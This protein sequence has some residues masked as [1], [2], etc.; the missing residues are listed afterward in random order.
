MDACVVARAAEGGVGPLARE[1][2]G[3]TDDGGPVHRR[4]LGAVA[5][6]CVR[7]L[8]V[9]GDVGGIEG[10]KLAA[11]RL[12]C[13]AETDEVDCDDGAERAV[14]DVANSVIASRD[15]TVAG[16]KLAIADPERV[17]AEVAGEPERSGCLASRC[18]GQSPPRTSPRIRAARDPSRPLPW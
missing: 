12:D 10:A 3:A 5:G 13:E 15:D 6:E 4:A 18:L 1:L 7:E 2:G 14:V 16:P 17:G 11:V 9:V 8:Q